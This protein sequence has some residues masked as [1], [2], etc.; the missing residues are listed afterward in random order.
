MGD[1]LNEI[2]ENEWFLVRHSGET[3]EIAL[4]SSIYYLT[5]AKEGPSATLN[6]DQLDSLLK[7]AIERFSEIVL[8]DLQHA[9]CGNESYRGLGRSIIN[10]RRFCTFCLRQK[11]DPG[12]VRRQ[13]ANAL[14]VFL[15]TE[16]AL[17]ND[18]KRPSIINCSYRELQVFAAELGIDLAGRFAGIAALCLPI[19]LMMSENRNIHGT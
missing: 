1:N 6:K 9:N 15:A 16:F 12:E 10:Y 14:Q 7:A 17:V 19:D 5:R 13:T 11:I 2:L 18:G 4:H 3:P 8:R